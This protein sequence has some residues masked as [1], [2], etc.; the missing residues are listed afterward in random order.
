MIAGNSN[1]T[2]DRLS[3]G[4]A[5]ELGK[6]IPVEKPVLKKYQLRGLIFQ[7]RDLIAGDADGASDPVKFHSHFHAPVP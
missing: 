7:G 2:D 6:R 3:M 4:A 5:E 1:D